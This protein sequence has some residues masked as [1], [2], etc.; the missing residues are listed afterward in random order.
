MSTAAYASPRP[1]VLADVVGGTRTRDIAL[2]I[3]GALLVALFAQ[4][5]IP[6][7][8]SPV[9]VTGQ[10]LAVGIVGASLGAN[11]GVTSLM[12]Y[13]ALGF[14]LPVY[15]DGGSGFDHLFGTNGGYIVGFVVAAFLIGKAAERGADRKPLLAF[16]AF[17]GAQLAVFGIGVPW[18]Y[19][20]S[21]MSW[22]D[23]VHYGFTVFILGGLVKAAIGAGVTPAAWR[24]V[25]K[26][27][28]RSAS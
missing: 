10:T 17:C 28:E 14:F 27:E 25:K 22:G 16:A 21:D 12:L 26:L 9:P 13:V 3:A 11:R 18:L 5:T 2:V 15:S 1:V 4:I 8:G 20:A 19:V 6:V 24:G 23:T 7:P